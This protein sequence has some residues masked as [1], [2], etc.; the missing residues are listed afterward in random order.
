LIDANINT[1]KQ[2]PEIPTEVTK[3]I[4][5]GTKYKYCIYSTYITIMYAKIIKDIL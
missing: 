3:D 2:K 1:T 4:D 5:V